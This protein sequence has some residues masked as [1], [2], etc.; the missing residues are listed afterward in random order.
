MHCYGTLKRVV[1]QAPDPQGRIM[2]KRQ[3]QFEATS[4]KGYWNLP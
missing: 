1:E 4:V 2:G 3:L